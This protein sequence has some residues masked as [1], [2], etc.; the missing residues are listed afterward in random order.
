MADS[1]TILHS[2][3]QQECVRL[4]LVAVLLFIAP[5]EHYCMR[6]FKKKTTRAKLWFSILSPQTLKVSNGEMQPKG[7]N[8][9][10]LC[11]CWEITKEVP[12]SKGA[13]A[14]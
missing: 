12:P 1:G 9:V 11:G 4:G 2:F 6:V 8:R 3:G 5:H 10:T 13:T 14:L 7:R